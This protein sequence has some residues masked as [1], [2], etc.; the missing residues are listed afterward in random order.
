MKSKKLLIPITFLFFT[1]IS[2]NLFAS[3]FAD[4]FGFS[5]EGMARGNA[6][7]ATVNDWSSV[8]YNVAG[9][10]K[11]QNITEAVQEGEMTLKLRKEGEETDEKKIYPNQIA[12]GFMYVIP[13]MNL[14]IP[15]RYWYDPP[16]PSFP[17]KTNAKDMEPYGFTTVGA[18]VDIN[19]LFKM[20]DF[21][22]SAR[23]G[24]GMGMNADLSLVKV[25]DVDPRTHDFL[26]HGKEIQRAIIIIGGALGYLN[27]AI[28][29][30]LGVNLAFSGKANAY[31]DTSLTGNPQIPI[32]ES[33]MELKVAPGIVAGAY[34][35]PGKIFSAIDG[36]ELGASYRQET[37][38]KIDPFNA[39]AGILGGVIEMT[40]MLAI[41]DYYSPHVITGGVAYTRW[42]LTISGDINYEMWSRSTLSKVWKSS[43][44]GI[45]KYNDIM[46]YKAGLKYDIPLNVGTLSLM[47]GYSFIPSIIGKDAGT[48]PGIRFDSVSTRLAFGMYNFLDNDKHNASLGFKYTLPKMGRFGGQI[49]FTVSYQL[50]YLVPKSVSKTGF[51]Y[52][53]GA[54]TQDDPLQ[55]YLLNP[56]YSYGGMNHSVFVEVGMRI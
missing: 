17:L 53:I 20:P 47:T 9:L 3:S 5:A 38:L 28:G 13:Q 27:D 39:G 15:Q 49:V 18:V 36:L 40:L 42:G 52:D 41:W 26:R 56:S 8:Y 31:M 11:T 19:N 12:L 44:I 24:L 37:V 22:S 6:M 32:T 45:P 1:G 34:L 51:S 25:N 35:S 43:C 54:G 30:G 55:T 50:Q 21:I 23:L 33:M 48:K 46:V 29:L 2:A 14:N 10:G 7:T 16:N 4:T